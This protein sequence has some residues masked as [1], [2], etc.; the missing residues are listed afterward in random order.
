[1]S[2]NVLWTTVF[3]Y[4]VHNVHGYIGFFGNFAKGIESNVLLDPLSYQSAFQTF[5]DYGS[6][7]QPSLI[8]GFGSYG[9]GLLPPFSAK[10]YDFKEIYTGDLI[11][12]KYGYGSFGLSNWQGES[13]HF[14]YQRYTPLEH[15]ESSDL[16]K[17]NA[18]AVVIKK[19]VKVIKPLVGVGIQTLPILDDGYEEFRRHKYHGFYGNQGGNGEQIF[20]NEGLG[21]Q[22]YIHSNHEDTL[23]P[24]LLGHKLIGYDLKTLFGDNVNPFIFSPYDNY[25]FNAVHDSHSAWHFQNLYN[26]YKLNKI[27]LS[28]DLHLQ[29]GPDAIYNPL[30]KHFHVLHKPESK[31]EEIDSEPNFKELQL[32][33]GMQKPLTEH[34]F[35][36]KENHVEILENYDLQKLQNFKNTH[37][38]YGTH[39]I[40][41][42]RE[43]EGPEL[44]E[45]KSLIPFLVD[46]FHNL[47]GFDNYL[48]PFDPEGIHNLKFIIANDLQGKKYHFTG[49][50]S[51]NGFIIH[52][53]TISENIGIID[54]K[55]NHFNPVSAENL[56]L[57]NPISSEK[58][59]HDPQTSIPIGPTGTRGF[60]GGHYGR[61]APYVFH[62]LKPTIEHSFQ[63]SYFRPFPPHIF[64]YH[65]PVIWNILL[66]LKNDFF[67]T[68]PLDSEHSTDPI[69]NKRL[70]TL[71]IGYFGPYVFN[72]FLHHVPIIRN[73]FR[74]SE[75]G[76]PPHIA[77]HIYQYSTPHALE[78]LQN[79]K[80]GYFGPFSSPLSQYY[81][82]ILPQEFHGYSYSDKYIP[83]NLHHKPGRLNDVKPV[84]FHSFGPLISQTHTDEHQ[85]FRPIISH[86]F[87][88]KSPTELSG[89]H[90]YKQESFNPVSV[91]THQYSE[92]SDVDNFEGGDNRGLQDSQV[93]PVSPSLAQYYGPRSNQQLHGQEHNNVDLFEPNKDLVHRE[94]SP[95]DFHTYKYNIKPLSDIEHE[96]P[97]EYSKG[98]HT[99]PITTYQYPDSYSET[100]HAPE[101]FHGNKI[102]GLYDIS[103]SYYDS[104]EKPIIYQED[105]N[106]IYDD[107]THKAEI[108]EKEQISPIFEIPKP[109]IDNKG[110]STGYEQENISTE[111]KKYDV[112]YTTVETV[113]NPKP[114]LPISKHGTVENV[115]TFTI[116]GKKYGGTAHKQVVE[117]PLYVTEKSINSETKYFNKKKLVS[118]VGSPLLNKGLPLGRT[119]VMEDNSKVI[120]DKSSVVIKETKI[121]I[122][123]F[124]LPGIV[125]KKSPFK[126]DIKPLKGNVLKP[127]NLLPQTKSFDHIRSSGFLPVNKILDPSV[128]SFTPETRKR[129][130]QAM[131]PNILKTIIPTISNDIMPFIAKPIKSSTLSK[132]GILESVNPSLKEP[133][134]HRLA[135]SSIVKSAKEKQVKS[136]ERIIVKPFKQLITYYKEPVNY[137]PIK[138]IISLKPEIVSPLKPVIFKPLKS[139]KPIILEHLKP[140]IL[141]H[142]KPI[143]LRPIFKSIIIEPAKTI[144][145]ILVPEIPIVSKIV[146]PNIDN[147]MNPVI[148]NVRN[149]FIAN[150]GK[151]FIEPIKPIIIEPVKDTTKDDIR[152]LVKPFIEPIKSIIL[153]PKQSNKPVILEPVKPILQPVQPFLKP[154]NHVD[155]HLVKP[156]I[157]KPLASVDMRLTQPV[158]LDIVKPSIMK[159]YKPIDL[160]PKFS[161]IFNSAK[162]V[163][164]ESAR[165]AILKPFEPFHGRLF[166]PVSLNPV[167][168]VSMELMKPNI[169]VPMK[170]TIFRPH[171]RTF[172]ELSKPIIRK[173]NYD[174]PSK[175]D[176]LVSAK[177]ILQKDI[178]LPVIEV[179]KKPITLKQSQYFNK[180]V[181]LANAETLK[182]NI[183]NPSIMIPSKPLISGQMVPPLIKSLTHAGTVADR[184][185]PV[186][187]E[188]TFIIESQHFK[189]KKVQ[190]MY[191]TGPNTQN[192]GEPVIHNNFIDFKKVIPLKQIVNKDSDRALDFPIKPT[193][194]D[195]IGTILENIKPTVNKPLV[196]D[197]A[198]IKPTRNSLKPILVAP[199]SY[200][201]H[202]IKP[203]GFDARFINPNFNEKSYV[204]KSESFGS[205]E[206]ISTSDT[207][208]KFGI[209]DPLIPSP[210]LPV[211]YPSQISLNLLNPVKSDRVP[212]E[213]HNRFISKPA[214][215][216]PIIPITN[217]HSKAIP[218]P[219]SSNPKFIDPKTNIEPIKS[220]P[221][222][223]NP[224]P[225]PPSLHPVKPFLVPS[226]LSTSA[227]FISTSDIIKI[228]PSRGPEPPE[229][230][231]MKEP[232]STKITGVPLNLA[233]SDPLKLSIVAPSR[234]L[235][236][237]PH[238]VP[239]PKTNNIIDPL[240]VR[241][242]NPKIHEKHFTIETKFFRNRK[243]ESKSGTGKTP[244]EPPYSSHIPV[245][246][247]NVP[248][249][250]LPSKPIPI[251]HNEIKIGHPTNVILQPPALTKAIVFQPVISISKPLT[252]KTVAIKKPEIAKTVEIEKPTIFKQTKPVVREKSYI[253]ESTS[254]KNRNIES[255]IGGDPGKE[256]VKSLK[257]VEPFQNKPE[258]SG[259]LIR[260]NID[261]ETPFKHLGPLLDDD[262]DDDE[263]D[264]PI[265]KNMKT[266]F[267][268]KPIGN[269]QKVSR[270]IGLPLLPP[271][272]NGLIKPDLLKE[273]KPMLH[274][275]SFNIKSQFHNKLIKNS[276]GKNVNLFDENQIKPNADFPIKHNLLLNQKIPT[277]HRI[278]NQP[279]TIYSDK[280]SVSL[281][282][283]SHSKPIP[284]PRNPISLSATKVV[285]TQEIREKEYGKKSEFI[286][287]KAIES[288]MNTNTKSSNELP[289]KPI[290]H[291]AIPKSSY[292]IKKPLILESLGD[293][294]LRHP[295]LPLP[296][297]TEPQLDSKV[298]NLPVSRPISPSKSVLNVSPKGITFGQVKPI[299]RDLKNIGDK[300]VPITPVPYI[301][302]ANPKFSLSHSKRPQLIPSV[303][304]LHKHLPKIS[305]EMTKQSN[306][307]SI[308][309]TRVQEKSVNIESNIFS[310]KKLVST[311]HTG[312]TGNAHSSVKPLSL[313]HASS[314]PMKPIHF[315]K[316]LDIS[317]DYKPIVPI[318]SITIA[319]IKSIPF[320]DRP[321]P[322]SLDIMKST[323]HP[324]NKKISSEP[325]KPIHFPKVLDIS[326]DSKPLVP[327]SSITIAPIKS[328]PFVDRPKSISLDSMKTTNHPINKKISPSI[329]EK[330][331][332]IESKSVSGKKVESS[333]GISDNSKINIPSTPHVV[334]PLKYLGTLPLK[335]IVRNHDIVT[336]TGIAYSRPVTSLHLSKSTPLIN[337]MLSSTGLSV[338]PIMPP[339]QILPDRAPRPVLPID[340]KQI[341]FAP[342]K[343]PITFS[344]NMGNK[345]VDVLPVNS[346]N[347]G[348]DKVKLHFSHQK[349]T[350]AV[351]ATIGLEKHAPKILIDTVK[352]LNNHPTKPI[353]QE[354]SVL[355][356][357]NLFSK[358]RVESTLDTG[359]IHITNSAAKSHVPLV[360]L[361]PT[362]HPKVLDIS[363]HSKPIVPIKP[364]VVGPIKSTPLSK[365]TNY[366]P[367][368]PMQITNPP[369]SKKTIPKIQE[370]SLII[371]SKLFSQ[372]K[373][374]SSVGTNDRSKILR[375]NTP[376]IV[377]PMKHLSI[378]PSLDVVTGTDYSRPF[379]S[380]NS[381]QKVPLDHNILSSTYHPSKPI[382]SLQPNQFFH[383][384]PPRP[385]LPTDTVLNIGTKPVTFENMKP[386]IE[387]LRIVSDKSVANTL[388]NYPHIGS[389][390]PKSSLSYV[391]LTPVVPE[392]IG[393]QKHE[394]KIVVGTA[395]HLTIVPIKPIVHEKSVHIESNLFSNKRLESTFDTGPIRIIN[396]AVNTHV[397][398]MPPSSVPLKPISIPKV[399]D[400]SVESKP[401]IPSRPIVITQIKPKP[402]T[403]HPK[404]IPLDSIKISKP[405]IIKEIRP[406]IQEKSLITESKAFSDQKFESSVATNEKSKI[407]TLHSP[408]IFG[409]L[410]HLPLKPIMPSDN[411]GS[412]IGTPYSRP[413]TSF[414]PPKTPLVHHI[415]NSKHLPLKPITSLP[416]NHIFSDR[417]PG[418]G[419]V[420]SRPMIPFKPAEKTP[421][422]HNI[423]E[424]IISV[425]PNQEITDRS[426]GKFIKN[427]DSPL[428]GHLNPGNIIKDSV[429]TDGI[430]PEKQNVF[431]KFHQSLFSPLGNVEKGG[432][433]PIIKEKSHVESAMAFNK[434]HTISNIGSSL[435]KNTEDQKIISTDKVNSFLANGRAGKSQISLSASK[436]LPNSK[437]S[438]DV[439]DLHSKNVFDSAIPYNFGD[440]NYY[441]HNE[442]KE[443]EI[444]DNQHHSKGSSKFTLLEAERAQ[445][446]RHKK[447]A[448]FKLHGISQGGDRRV[449]S[450]DGINIFSNIDTKGVA[451]L[452]SRDVT[453][454]LDNYHGYQNY[455]S[456]GANHENTYGYRH[457]GK[458]NFNEGKPLGF[459]KKKEIGL[460][461]NSL[462]GGKKIVFVQDTKPRRF[463]KKTN[464]MMKSKPQ[465]VTDNKA[466]VYHV[467][468]TFG[469]DDKTGITAIKSFNA[470]LDFDSLPFEEKNGKLDSLRDYVYG[471]KRLGVGDLYSKK[472]SFGGDKSYTLE[473]KSGIVDDGNDMKAYKYG[474]KLDY[475]SDLVD[476][477]V[478]PLKVDEGNIGATSTKFGYSRGRNYNVEKGLGLGLRKRY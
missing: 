163:A 68:I 223:L 100:S 122:H 248:L 221:I 312:P 306:I 330:Y 385:I 362:N 435:N 120:T 290:I 108:Q 246:S 61:L 47:E 465:H 272:T 178:V 368:D 72:G 133:R 197:K 288:V 27:L 392:V 94:T 252:V 6:D 219:I 302:P 299:I 128:T 399:L 220:T 112:P 85:A 25:G 342:L 39:H 230:L 207:G 266:L 118:N 314:E 445:A 87:Q 139:I 303:I 31:F 369:I 192:I 66:G 54:I 390:K 152:G 215:I 169:L 439:E 244:D 357:S 15:H 372:K 355:I 273:V 227:P 4:I 182:Q 145:P 194:K 147:H 65:D 50:H 138:P 10:K 343:P 400:I 335:P 149:P 291:V 196:H 36:Q 352:H 29:Q 373:V 311:F 269:E 347:I 456:Y 401:V 173:P 45:K 419:S 34:D 350:P 367:L 460:D 214:L 322:I 184:S 71:E 268:L 447:A 257:M 146:K 114:T 405:V 428:N 389:V 170:P 43:P 119:N 90:K 125:S 414:Y 209:H 129:E 241:E 319:P 408:L 358:K 337:N 332:V 387:P 467:E 229:R 282:G 432:V 57:Y 253:I 203:S 208:N 175:P 307:D 318:S 199:V 164:L 305:I 231:T 384:R 193:L 340:S 325:M 376:H 200:K 8:G 471:F 111:D 201:L 449:S 91:N 455:P 161:A 328:I 313:M 461:E 137:K 361:K 258:K 324:I 284:E 172:T 177:K 189:N 70:D 210:K 141:K 363:V 293:K 413:V 394:P 211:K 308:K 97:T 386:S 466:I 359:P 190:T 475:K 179:P 423:L 11:G 410:K 331:L 236:I 42:F 425:P 225:F 247:K 453:G 286:T 109:I 327:I 397:P 224:G 121:P 136:S 99:P 421:I 37:I 388:L 473:N 283:K 166:K 382:I 418:T 142:S 238:L 271:I 295:K 458:Y 263:D 360:P 436:E 317:V 444:D 165:P 38:K 148:L 103:D 379:I 429:R 44:S 143:S 79:V 380:F 124:T 13:P 134:S 243:I 83:L 276:V 454:K 281:L 329:Q 403:E 356:E 437:D 240:S 222:Q 151:P 7:G 470:G 95:Q 270:V 292:V 402:L 183:L 123:G 430:G 59:L 174:I 264:G 30:H 441:D 469:M 417:S 76:L 5:T 371:E 424:P 204:I 28:R 186:I 40:E 280:P 14:P 162:H 409:S 404:Y 420:N 110:V 101:I 107:I 51:P 339:T 150:L 254:F 274:E 67:H 463:S 213:N 310:N 115:K 255:T 275:T 62:D 415:V 406:S 300:I 452:K 86:S 233:V 309:P 334:G 80:Q 63:H 353:T 278:I 472:G 168:P 438:F 478:K 24:G 298:Y 216:S 443:V 77:P 383:E 64:K 242:M 301:G 217:I 304:G 176:T 181:V 351:P 159:P 365:P 116:E 140:A 468:K 26:N 187:H 256:S 348:F 294:S 315:P 457:G 84:F 98:R 265:M 131:K 82:Q 22:A 398:S 279:K 89:L 1:M 235:T 338:K 333:V 226:I 476:G 462:L 378:V 267:P 185:K 212:Y 21:D 249:I 396:K 289:I 336:G 416:L 78:N 261:N 259:I 32:L 345:P 316:V 377:G 370:K 73:N 239:P 395:K 2:G 56:H 198:F 262:D 228:I 20:Q 375:P 364:I 474:K 326:V 433:K 341:I 92:S 49:Q 381:P 74:K 344:R 105:V 158:N 234:P 102:K 320:V 374:E 250:H 55:H 23:H 296:V 69:I 106:N 442:G 321:K 349:L 17:Q 93:Y 426:K 126:K 81:R 52:G 127:S 188:K 202:V 237:Q 48:G 323:N 245:N 33:H 19:T 53:P 96:H 366:I 46:G 35:F 411:I 285:A 260:K 459:H 427:L 160:Q 104:S 18:I 191:N 113:S 251:S 195:K 277:P 58:N 346:P 218:V 153:E 180:P 155:L 135:T 41:D 12:S 434:I 451:Y 205:K 422:V 88:H 393:I 407:L 156:V 130:L 477:D 206:I 446:I 9:T 431:H 297:I 75:H 132:P 412:V 117:V 167:K 440:E 354:R 391:K 464:V 144:K 154:T 3:L 450:L 287:T 171:E 60:L 232:K 157:L 448:H 16:P